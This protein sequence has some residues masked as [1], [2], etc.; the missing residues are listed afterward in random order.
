MPDFVSMHFGVSLN[1]LSL[2]FFGSLAGALWLLYVFCKRKLPNA[3]RPEGEITFINC[4]HGNWR[5][6]RNIPKGS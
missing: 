4:C 2:L 5:H 6:R 1:K 3:A